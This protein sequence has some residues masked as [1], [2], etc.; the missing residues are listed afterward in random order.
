MKKYDL[1]PQCGG[2]REHLHQMDEVQILYCMD[3]KR[4]THRTHD[5]V[6]PDTSAADRM[7]D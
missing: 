3:C 6:T 4:E 5:L 7:G 2:V 1:C